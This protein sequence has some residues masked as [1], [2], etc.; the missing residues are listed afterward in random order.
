MAR[1]AAG[2]LPRALPPAA[3]DNRMPWHYRLRVALGL[4]TIVALVLGIAAF[5]M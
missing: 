5:L 1:V 3:N 4:A 2:V